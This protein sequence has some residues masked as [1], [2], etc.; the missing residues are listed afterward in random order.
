MQSIE[1]NVAALVWFSVFAG[2]A[3]TGFYVL[4]GAFPLETRPDLRGRP[5]G[6]ALLA[7]NVILLALLVGGGLAY[8]AAHLR[9]TSLVIV[10][11]LALL[12]APGLFNVWPERWRDG[13]A[14]LA[15]VLA[16][17]G[18]SLGL[19]QAVGGVFGL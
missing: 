14:G 5:L 7:A 13:P 15:I 9:W 6:L 12:F 11:G 18:L 17:T 8:G 1:P 2:V 16:G 3:S 4:A 19:M 10:G